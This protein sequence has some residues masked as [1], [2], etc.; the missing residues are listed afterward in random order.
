MD[1]SLKIL[2]CE[3]ITGINLRIWSEYTFMNIKVLKYIL[4]IHKLVLNKLWLFFNYK[5][6]RISL[7]YR[8]LYLISKPLNFG[9]QKKCYIK[10]IKTSNDIKF[11]IN[12]NDTDKIYN[13]DY[14][15]S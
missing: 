12:R 8:N 4:I 11:K 7:N 10:C 5:S 1:L 15:S 13:N 9:P 2:L 14:Y 6:L 3:C